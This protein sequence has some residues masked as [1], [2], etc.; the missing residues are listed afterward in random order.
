MYEILVSI[1]AYMCE[2]VLN[3][4]SVYTKYTYGKCGVLPVPQ[5]PI[6]LTVKANYCYDGQTRQTA[7]INL[8]RQVVYKAA[9]WK[10]HGWCQIQTT[11]WQALF[12]LILA[13][14]PPQEGRRF[15]LI[16]RANPA[17]SFLGFQGPHRPLKSFYY[18]FPLSTL[19]TSTNPPGPPP[20]AGLVSVVVQYAYALGGSIATS[21]AYRFLLYRSFWVVRF[22]F[23]GTGKGDARGFFF[24]KPSRQIW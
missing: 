4:H 14:G 15:I 22:I 12:F 5:G 19:S 11:R 21:L 3:Q 2:D 10:A 13:L 20:E 8:R 17:R 9:E 16:L 7:V 1:C 18:L 6:A 24:E 23:G